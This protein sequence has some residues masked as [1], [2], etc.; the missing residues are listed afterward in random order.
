MVSLLPTHP[1]QPLIPR[2]PLRHPRFILNMTLL[3]RQ[4]GW[5]QKGSSTLILMRRLVTTMIPIL[6]GGS[7]V[8]SHKSHGVVHR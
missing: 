2:K 3:S 6:L 1:R 8:T 5:I 7:D 4:G